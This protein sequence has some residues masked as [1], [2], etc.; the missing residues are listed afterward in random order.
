MNLLI[1]KQV[2]YFTAAWVNS[3]QCKA[4]FCEIIKIKWVVNYCYYSL[5]LPVVLEPFKYFY[6]CWCIFNCDISI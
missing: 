6:C 4:L 5:S 2:E 3:Q 1:P